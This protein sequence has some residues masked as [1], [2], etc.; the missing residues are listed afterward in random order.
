MKVY[1]KIHTI[2]GQ[3]KVLPVETEVGSMIYAVK[4]GDGS[5]REQQQAVRESS[6]VLQISQKNMQPRDTVPML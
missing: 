1:E 6:V 3:E 5:A 4:P 2:A